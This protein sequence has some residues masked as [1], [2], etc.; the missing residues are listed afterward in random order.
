MAAVFPSTTLSMLSSPTQCWH[1][2]PAHFPSQYCSKPIAFL[3]A[4]GLRQKERFI[5]MIGDVVEKIRVVT[6]YS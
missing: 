6:R 5:A 3:L 1:Q 2:P 4:C